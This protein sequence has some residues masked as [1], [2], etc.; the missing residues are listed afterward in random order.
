MVHLRGVLKIEFY[1]WHLWTLLVELGRPCPSSL[2]V[3]PACVPWG[4]VFCIQGE[5]CCAFFPSFLPVFG[6]RGCCFGHRR[7]VFSCPFFVRL[8]AGCIS[9]CCRQGRAS[10]LVRPMWGYACWAC[11]G[12]LCVTVLWWL[13]VVYFGCWFISFDAINFGVLSVP[14]RLPLLVE[15][16]GLEPLVW[17]LVLSWFWGFIFSSSSTYGTRGIV[18]GRT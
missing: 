3:L 15:V 2:L 6:V 7:L 11:G 1:W 12:V 4:G 9:M 18:W 16:C 8:V 10:L 13:H 14:M 5:V 17:G